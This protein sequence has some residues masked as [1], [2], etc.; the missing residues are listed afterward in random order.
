MR[1][2]AIDSIS[3][4]TVEKLVELVGEDFQGAVGFR[5]LQENEGLGPLKPSRVWDDGYP[6][7]EIL[8]GTSTIGLTGGWYYMNYEQIQ[9]AL[10]HLLT[11]G[12]SYRRRPIDGYLGSRIGLIVGPDSTTGN[13]P[14]ELIISSAECIAIFE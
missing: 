13:D 10:T 7:E 4:L 5:R 9:E 1:I 3:D 2:T 6:T 8:E 12:G 14:G 11:V